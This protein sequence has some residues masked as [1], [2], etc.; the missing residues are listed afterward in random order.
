[1]TRD[2]VIIS[3]FAETAAGQ[4]AGTCNTV[5]LAGGT[6]ND[7]EKVGKGVKGEERL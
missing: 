1:M 3:G 6:I 4:F 7:R 2:G 5:R